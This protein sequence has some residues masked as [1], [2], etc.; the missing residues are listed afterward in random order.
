G[1]IAGAGERQHGRAGHAPGRADEEKAA[2]ARQRICPRAKRGHGEHD[3]EVGKRKCAGECQRAPGMACGDY[4]H[5]VC[6]EHRGEHHGG[7][8][9]IGKIVHGP[10]PE[11]TLGDPW[12]QGLAQP[13]RSMRPGG[14]H[15][16]R[17]A[18]PARAIWASSS[19]LTPD[20]PTAPTTCPSWTMGTPP[21][22]M[23]SSGAE[24]KA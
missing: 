17:A 19:D 2:P 12:V 20:T 22:S 6:A 13:G 15:A 3:E 10:C 7:V 1:D 23:P 9:R 24:R 14:I 5:K 4:A 11:L 8:A 18:M 21:S 16:C